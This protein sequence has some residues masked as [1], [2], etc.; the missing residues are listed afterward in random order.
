MANFLCANY[1][2]SIKDYN[3]AINI[4]NENSLYFINLATSKKMMKDYNGALKDINSAIKLDSTNSFYFRERGLIKNKLGDY[5]GSLSDLQKALANST[6]RD[7]KRYGGYK[8]TEIKSYQSNLYKEIGKVEI[9]LK[10]YIKAISSLNMSISL[11]GGNSTYK[12]YAKEAFLYRGIAKYELKDY[13]SAC[14]DWYFKKQ[15][16]FFSSKYISDPVI[17]QSVK[18]NGSS[19]YS[20]YKKHCK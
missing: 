17:L 6:L 1:K 11:S 10:D 13:Q 7:Y 2:E 9:K 20:L 18:H 19:I 8:Y 14:S 4:N 16:G 12:W 15:V 5:L 3:L